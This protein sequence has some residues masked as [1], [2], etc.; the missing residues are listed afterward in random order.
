MGEW[1]RFPDE[2]YHHGVKGQKWGVIRKRLKTAGHAISVGGH[3]IAKTTLR[4]KAYV[5]KVL[6]QKKAKNKSP[7]HQ[8]FPCFFSLNFAPKNEKKA[9]LRP[10]GDV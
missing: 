10:S 8:I 1:V 9:F 7:L 2:L 5:D 6:T 3:S 4:G